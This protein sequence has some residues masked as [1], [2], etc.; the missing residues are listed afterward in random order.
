MGHKARERLY[1]TL[2]LCMYY[3]YLICIL[4]TELQ[5]VVVVAVTTT[6]ACLSVLH[7]CCFVYR[8]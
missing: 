5:H 2:R 8:M 3:M 7:V 4:D 6:C 1:I